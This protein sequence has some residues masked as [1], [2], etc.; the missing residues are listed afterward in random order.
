MF[1]VTGAVIVTFI[2]YRSREKQM[3]IEHDVKITGG[4]EDWP[5]YGDLISKRDWDKYFEGKQY[6]YNDVLMFALVRLPV[7]SCFS[8]LLDKS[9]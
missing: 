7:L 5:D 3:V 6:M 4:N 8:N 9:L 1:L 2:F